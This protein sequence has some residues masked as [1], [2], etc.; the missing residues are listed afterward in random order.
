MVAKISDLQLAYEL[1][2]T[3]LDT[4]PPVWRWFCVPGEI[5]L[6]RLH[7]V[8][9]IVMGWQDHHLHLFK[10]DGTIYA[11]KPEEEWEGEE[12]KYHRLCDLVTSAKAQFDYDYDFGDSWHHRIVVEKISTVPEGHK[13]VTKCFDGKRRCPPEDV[14]GTPGFAEFVEAC[15]DPKHPE[16]KRYLTW[17]GGSFDPNDFDPEAVNLELFKYVRWS[18][19]R[20][21]EIDLA[22]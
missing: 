2:I 16:H 7:N 19:P 3:L 18:R 20:A 15:K 10:I 12:E 1:K 21:S 22:E 6:D 4:K 13:A 17:V 14:G 9:Q 8:I 5:T 11:E